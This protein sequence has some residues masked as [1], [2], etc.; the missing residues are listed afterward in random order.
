MVCE[1]I[2]KIH[3]LIHSFHFCIKCLLNTCFVPD[4]QIKWILRDRFFT[5]IFPLEI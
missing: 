2:E 4:A 1:H 5:M 3:L